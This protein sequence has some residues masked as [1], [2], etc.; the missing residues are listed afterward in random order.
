ML[1]REKLGRWALAAGAGF[2]VFLVVSAFVWREDILRTWLDPKQPF[3]TY[4]PPPAPNYDQQSAWALI[5]ANPTLWSAS[6]PPADV[7]FIHPTTFDGGRDWNGPIDDRAVDRRLAEVMLPNYA[8][9][10]QRV[11]RVFAPRYRQASLYAFMTNREDA[12]AAREFAYADVRRAFEIF[13]TRYNDTRPIVI[14]GIEQGGELASHLVE[15][16]VARDPKRL[17]RLAA[18][19]M[20]DAIVPASDYGAGARVPACQRPG[21]PRC[22]MAWRAVADRNEAAQL[23]KRALVW[24]ADGRLD[25]LGGKAPLCSN[26]ILGSATSALAP[27]RLNKGAANASGMEWGVR[28]AF[29]PRQVSAQCIDGY[30]RVSTPTSPSLRPSGNWTDRLKAPPFNLFYADEEADAK[31]RVAALAREPGY[32][33]PIPPVG[34]S[35]AVAHA[36]VYRIP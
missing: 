31:G 12:Q 23:S 28:P 22:A 29:M 1:R 34:A 30:L 24:T 19:Y 3:Q 25:D 18:V 16:A 10:F 2:I 20:V 4:S 9:P 13:I 7:F 6:D 5:P 27:D 32:V 14:V 21:Q 15:D 35:I 26:P 33:A 36:P 8:G 17:A 11:G